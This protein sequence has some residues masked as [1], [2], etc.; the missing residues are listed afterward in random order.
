MRTHR[1]TRKLGGDGYVYYLNCD[2]NMSVYIHPNSPSCIHELRA[3]ILY[4]IYTL[5]SSGG[6]GEEEDT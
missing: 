2:G 6:A 5:I 3:V 4:T 1:D